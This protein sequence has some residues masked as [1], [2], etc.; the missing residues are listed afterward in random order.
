MMC[1][2]RIFCHAQVYPYLIYTRDYKIVQMSDF[3]CLR[4]LDKTDGLCLWPSILVLRAHFPTLRLLLYPFSN[5]A[6]SS[7]SFLLL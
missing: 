3:M 4:H 2:V 1:S 6:F 7:C 5:T